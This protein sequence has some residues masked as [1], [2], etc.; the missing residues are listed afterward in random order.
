MIRAFLPPSSQ[1]TFLMWRWPGWGWAARRLISRPTGFE[2]VK[3][4]TA[5]SGCSTSRAPTSS[6]RPGRSWNTPGGGAGCQ[7]RLGQPPGHRGG[8][9]GRL[10]DHRVAGRQGR[11]RHAA[12][13]GQREVPRGDDRRDPL[14]LVGQA[15]GLARRRLHE[16]GG[17]SVEAEDLPA[18]V[19]AEVDGLA[20][21]G[22]GLV[23]RLGRLEALEGGE[24]VA[25]LGASSRRPGR[26]ARPARRR[27]VAATTAGRATAAATAASASAAVHE[28]EVATTRSCGR[29]RPR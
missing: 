21:V 1:T 18:V 23:P 22:V 5:T 24:L 10:Q 29:G 8:L 6:P 25:T 9:L 4:I 27:A 28:A 11:H 2:P 12:G 17:R 3:A 15:V 14:A 19:L 13:D 7:Q 26:G 16:V 20:H